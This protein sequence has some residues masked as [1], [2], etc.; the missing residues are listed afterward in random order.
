M[1]TRLYFHE[2]LTS[3]INLPGSRQSNGPGVYMDS[4]DNENVHRNMTRQIGSL[5]ASKAVNSAA[6]TSVLE[7]YYTAFVSPPLT[8]QSIS[9]GTWTYNIAV[10]QS[11]LSA[12]FPVSGANAANYVCCYLWRPGTGLVGYFINGNTNTNWNEPTVISTRVVEH[13]TF[14][15]AAQTAQLN[16]VIILELTSHHTQ[17]T[18]TSRV[19]GFIYDGGTVN[20]TPGATNTDPAAFLEIPQ[21]LVFTDDVPTSIDCTSDY[22]DVLQQSPQQLITNSI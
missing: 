15:A 1:A 21:D 14:S 4:V 18:A 19:V 3:L 7:Y 13:T 16:D 8:A 9:S 11:S 12:N 6:S 20:T 17:A 5:P 22:K 10:S 2:E